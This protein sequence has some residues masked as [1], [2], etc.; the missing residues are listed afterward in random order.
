MQN[1]NVN[2][3]DI[4]KNINIE[5]TDK[6]LDSTTGYNILDANT[7]DDGRIHLQYNMQIE[8]PEHI[9]K[10][11]ELIFENITPPIE[12]NIFHKVSK[13]KFYN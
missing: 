7:R 1:N 9:E 8:A 12:Y 3:R 4:L 13:V 2:F 6:I 10:L 5:E 11:L